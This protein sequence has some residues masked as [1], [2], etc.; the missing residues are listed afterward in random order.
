[1]KK[2][3][4]LLVVIITILSLSTVMSQDKMWGSHHQYVTSQAWSLVKWIHGE[5]NSTDPTSM[6]Q[7]IGTNNPVYG[8]VLYA[9]ND[10]DNNEI[11]YTYNL[12]CDSY[13]LYTCTHF[14]DITEFDEGDDSYLH[15]GPCAY[16]NAYM[17]AKNFWT[18]R[19]WE[20]TNQH[21]F[22]TF[23]YQDRNGTN[24]QQFFVYNNLMDAIHNHQNIWIAQTNTQLRSFIINNTYLTP[25]EVDA[26]IDDIL[27][28]VVGRICHLIED[29]SMPCHALE[30]I[31]NT[32]PITILGITY[33]A[34]P[35]YYE[36]TY[37][38]NHYQYIGIFDAINKGGIMNINYLHQPLRSVLCVTNEIANTFPSND[39]DATSG[40]ANPRGDAFFF[41]KKVLPIRWNVRNLTD[42][43]PENDEGL[44]IRIC[45][46]VL[47]YSF[48]GAIRAVA[49]F[50]YY[51]YSNTSPRNDAPYIS[52]VTQYPPVIN[53]NSPGRVICSLSSGNFPD[54]E[55]TWHWHEK[56]DYISISVPNEYGNYV[57]NEDSMAV[58]TNNNYLTIT[59]SPNTKLN[60]N[61]MNHIFRIGVNAENNNGMSYH[62]AHFPVVF[63]RGYI[64]SGCPW[65]YVETPDTSIVAENNILHKSQLP[66]NSGLFITDKYVLHNKP[67]VFDGKLNFRIIETN[68]DSTIFN[69][70]KLYAVDHPIGKKIAVTNSNTIVMFDSASVIQDNSASLFDP[71]NNYQDITGY[72]L[73][74]N[75]NGDLLPI[76]GDS[77]YN[78]YAEFASRSISYPGVISY[79][80]RG[81]GI[82]ITPTYKDN[83]SGYLYTNTPDR[84]YMSSFMRRENP[85]I[86]VYEVPVNGG[87]QHLG[88][89]DSVH[90][91][92]DKS[93]KIKYSAVASLLY[94]GFSTIE[95]PLV[96]ALQT[97]EGNVSQNLMSNDNSYSY[98]S[99]N[100]YLDLEFRDS[101]PYSGTI[102]VRDYVLEVNGQVLVMGNK[103]LNRKIT[104]K[105]QNGIPDKFSLSQNYPNPFNPVTKI[106]YGV[107]K[108]S[109]VSIKVYDLLG[110][111]VATLVNEA[112]NPG[113]YTVEFNGSNFASGIY[114]YRITAG[115]FTDVKRLVLIK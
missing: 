34:D 95:L 37:L 59:V 66:Q 46:S 26:K 74:H 51:V 39:E 11:M 17:K 6:D 102:T 13:G 65:L 58:T 2:N 107:P 14:L 112:K 84:S 5:V 115:T 35:D 78:I 20:E 24:H 50:L 96:N 27:Y 25:A 91:A 111:E 38:N 36:Q 10:E 109:L 56:P 45:D 54:V 42:H 18:S 104:G 71:E 63:Q 19:V 52:A 105:E 57:D 68:N 40:S 81:G 92:F 97:A 32:E 88:Q 101:V 48:T 16:P 83:F 1:M 12:P 43:W 79:L 69:S 67:G 47:K 64:Y 55:Y 110:R 77:L 86:N 22:L 98:I 61:E 94:S 3:I 100:S 106:N 87:K 85:D 4:I 80:E 41:N 76:N 15:I 62:S 73:F 31:H 7:R 21:P 103:M 29:M 44:A 93:F 53:S 9:S 89:V 99:P 113:M 90:I 70:V 82:A 49:G 23:N 75:N 72:I 33:P 30:D 60:P 108:Q 28:D 114:F 8:T